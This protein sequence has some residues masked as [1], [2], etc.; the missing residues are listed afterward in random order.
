VQVRTLTTRGRVT[1]LAAD[2]NRVA[3]IVSA[4][5]VQTGGRAYDCASVS[6]WE[7]IGGR[8]VELQ[9]P[10]GSGDDVSLRE[11][12]EGVALAGTRA[13]WLHLDGG[14]TLE[15]ILETATL[16]QPKPVWVA[17]GASDESGA[18]DFAR[19]PFGD[20]TLLAFT[21]ERHC[22]ADAVLNQGP[23]APNQC[24]PGGTTGDIT[25]ATAWRTGGGAR[26]P[27]MNGFNGNTKP[28]GVRRCA[29]IGSAAGELSVLAVDAGRVLV[30]TE[31]GLSLLTAAGAVLQTFD[32]GALSAQLS[33][34]RLAVRTADAVEVFDTSSAQQTARFPA[35]R[36]LTLQDLDRNILVTAS[37]G[38]VTLRRLTDNRTSTIHAGGPALA[39]LEPAGLFVA[40]GRH[41]SF[42]PIRDVLRQ[43]HT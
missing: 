28:S 32:I 18:G 39:Q 6:V 22:D 3:L 16:A 27:Q 23:G 11:G 2:G 41:V 40:G 33:G 1:G 4:P 21:V 8:L 30:R 43:L 13:A 7:P 15:T 5:Y 20:G 42:T 19:Q 29:G 10:C 35:S 12:T 17:Y 31:S 25:A 24:P 37:G 38:T 34:N 36:G 14:N 9:R 26:C